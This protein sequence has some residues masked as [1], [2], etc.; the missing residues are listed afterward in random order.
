MDSV[1]VSYYR[2]PD[3]KKNELLIKFS[4]ILCMVKKP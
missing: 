4:V 2:Y 1:I 3:I